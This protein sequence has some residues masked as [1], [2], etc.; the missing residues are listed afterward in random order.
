M[1]DH[2]WD[3]P[4]LRDRLEKLLP[5]NSEFNDFLVEHEFPVIGYKKLL[6][7]AHIILQ[8]DREPQMFL[9]AIADITTDTDR[10]TEGLQA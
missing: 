9:L 2:Q 3:I 4:V 8:D 5:Q 10:A 7:T 6:L 1:G